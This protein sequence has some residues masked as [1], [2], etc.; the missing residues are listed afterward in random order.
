MFSSVIK[1]LLLL[2]LLMGIS[3]LTQAQ[4]QNDLPKL[5]QIGYY[6]EATKFAV[7]P[8][9]SATTF[10]I[11]D[12]SDE[13]IVYQGTL[14]NAGSYPHTGETLKLADFSEFNLPGMYR[15]YIDGSAASTPFEIRNEVYDSLNSGL[16]KALYYNR[17]STALVET[18]AG[19]W[20]RLAGH[21][22]DQVIIHASAA[23]D[24]RPAGSTISSPGG[25]YDA[26]DFNKYVVPISSSISHLLTTYEHFPE[27]YNARDLNIPESDNSVP[28]ILDESMY[29]LNWLLTMQDPADGGV[30]HKLTHANFQGT[31]MP[32]QATASRYVVQK[33]TTASLDFAAVMAQASR[34]MRPYYPEFADTA[35]VVAERAYD[36]AVANPSVGYDQTAMNNSYDPDV[37]TGGYGDGNFDD[38]FF[39]ARSELYITTGDDTYYEPNGWN[40]TGNSGWGNVRALGLFSLLHHRKDLTAVGLADTSSMKN[41]LINNFDWYVND[42]AASPY[43]SPFGIESWQFGWG[44]NGGAG[45]LG[46]AIMMMYEITGDQKYYDGANRVLDYLLG[47]NG[48][49]YSYVTGFGDI[50]PMHIHHRQSQADAVEAPT[51]GW[52][53]GG[54]NPG[55]Q[56]QDCGT[57][58]YNSTLPALSYADLYC[59]YSTNEIT[60]YW[61]SP[62]VFLTA[63]LE[64]FTDDVTVS[65]DRYV[66]MQN[67]MS[68]IELDYFEA[69]DL[70]DLNW[71]SSNVSSVNIAYKAYNSEAFTVLASGIDAGTGTYTGFEIP[72][73]PGDSL[74]IKVEDADAGDTP[75]NM[76]VVRIKPS[77]SITISKISTWYPGFD[78]G[79]RVSI[80]WTYFDVDTMDL[81]Y[82]LSSSDTLIPISLGIP[83]SDTDYSN[84]KVPDAP[85]D[86]L[87]FR[88]SDSNDPDVYGESEPFYIPLS[89]SSD[90]DL[91]GITN[92]QLHQNYPNPFNPTTVIN[93]QLPVSERVQLKVFDTVGREVSLLV[94]Q[95]QPAG[96]Y[97]VTFDAGDLPSGIYLYQLSTQSVT[98]TKK[99]TLIK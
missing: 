87:R 20:E 29:A 68:T 42:G 61:N 78:P 64:H 67:P 57:S 49:G 88:V 26:G 62:F 55:N 15:L 98:F 63:A 14:T 10:H 39:W 91:S 86:T 90:E 24:G 83:N 6:P 58:A 35:L 12:I 59:S 51:P 99:M 79:N 8:D 21:P 5:N 94:D 18:Y 77:K 93:Y 44:S 19:V 70:I 52:V 17:A 47:M 75:F 23:S 7:T 45:N 38:E 2:S 84:F 73:L 80:E 43:R 33:S 69:G 81:H 92:F 11:R 27:L 76:A 4:S 25:W 74:I 48:V 28:D 32:H 82:S 9:Q 41:T 16:I 3:T 46:M 36:W 72:S 54:A 22:D 71:T 56:S 89:T 65:L 31:V 95:V 53:A 50:T 30:D 37:N 66:K 96:S 1:R 40:N 13:T 60:T 97:T 34:V 85:G